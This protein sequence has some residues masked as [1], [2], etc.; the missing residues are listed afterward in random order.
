MKILNK[1]KNVII[2]DEKGLEK[3]I[4]R[5]KESGTDRLH[6]LADF[7]RTLTKE[8]YNGIKCSSIISYLRKID[9]KYLTKDYANKARRLF[10]KYHPIEIDPKVS[11]IEKSKKMQEWWEKHFELLIKCGLDKKTIIESTKDM[12][13]ENALGFRKGVNEFLFFL[14]SKKIPLVIISSSVGNMI[15]EFFNQQG[16]ISKNITIISNEI[17]FDKNGKAK[18]IERIVHVF[19]K[20]EMELNKHKIHETIKNKKNVILLGDSIGDLKMVEGF[21]YDN[22]IRI[23]FLNDNIDEN[24]EAY[25]KGFDIIITNDGD[26]ESVNELLEKISGK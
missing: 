14:D 26:F 17:D 1:Q 23:G 9:G 18:G 21:E 3:K 22:L 20:N 2:V 25:K 6:V 4:K 13:E 10:E 15:K 5:I 8:F 12:I 7:D 11:M 24:I 19:N 16:L